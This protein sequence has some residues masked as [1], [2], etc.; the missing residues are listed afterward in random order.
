MDKF[1]TNFRKH[2]M[3]PTVSYNKPDKDIRKKGNYSLIFL[4]KRNVK[5]INK[6]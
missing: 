5:I 4:M 3:R 6:I 1:F 2:L